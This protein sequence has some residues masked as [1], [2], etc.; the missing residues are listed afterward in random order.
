MF[1]KI[2]YHLCNLKTWKTPEK[3]IKLKTDELKADD[4]LFPIKFLFF[5][6]NEPP[7]IFCYVQLVF[8]W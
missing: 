3:K 8:A 4:R 1:Y 6:Q 7:A 2:W 5:L